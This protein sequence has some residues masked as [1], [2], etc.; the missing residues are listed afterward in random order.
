M[1]HIKMTATECLKELG[2]NQKQTLVYCQL[3]VLEKATAYVIA[4]K[5]HLKR[6]TVYVILEELRQKGAVLKIPHVKKQ[7]FIPKSPQVL[8]QEVEHRISNARQ[9]LPELLAL[10]PKESKPKVLY[11]E[12]LNGIWESLQYKIDQLA[13]K[14]MVAFYGQDSQVSAELRDIFERY[15][16]LI[17]RLVI[18]SRSVGPDHPNLKKFRKTD[19]EFHRQVKQIPLSL[20]DSN[21][22]IEIADTFVRLVAFKDLQAT[23]IENVEIA[24]SLKKIF[25]LVWT[26]SRNRLRC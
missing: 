21:I 15:Q 1:Y 20:Y 5:S 23:I 14:E 16:Q 26:S 12:G 11:F 25:E 4:E 13:G 17:K 8:F 3:L 9:M 2:F 10:M 18:R 22:S 6:S 19:V 24:K 7:L